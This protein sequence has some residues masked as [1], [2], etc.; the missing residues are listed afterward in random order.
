MKILEVKKLNKSYNFN[1]AKDINYVLKNFELEVFDKDFVVIM[2]PSGAGKT[3]I[4]NSI[5]GIDNIDSGEIIYNGVDIS[6]YNENDMANL[7]RYDFS[8]VFQTPNLIENMTLYENCIIAKSNK[9]ENK[10]VDELFEKFNLI[11]E[12]TKYPNEVS[13]GE[14]ARVAIIR[15]VSKKPKILFVDEPTGSLNKKQSEI[16]LDMLSR[17]NISG[18][19]I[20]MVTHDINAAVYGNR[21]IYIEDGNIKNIL[22]FDKSDDKELKYKKVYEVLNSNRW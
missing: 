15:A 7:R 17:I 2:G 19:Q 9:I 4:L 20:V 5:S 16:V 22:N 3:T 12:K 14:L 6:K 13:G 18:T 1:G 21:L 8:F 11:S 10:Y